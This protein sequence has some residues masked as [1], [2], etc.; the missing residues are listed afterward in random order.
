MRLLCMLLVLASLVQWSSTAA[1]A[2]RA[3]AQVFCKIKN[4]TECRNNCSSPS[5]CQT[6]CVGCPKECQPACQE[7]VW[8]D[9][10]L[11]KLWRGMTAEQQEL[12]LKGMKIEE[13]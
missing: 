13:R 10:G 11:N 6:G 2:A 1:E 5:S 4:E 3:S 8:P 7:I 9:D 12:F